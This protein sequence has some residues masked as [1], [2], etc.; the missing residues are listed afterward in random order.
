MNTR[1]LLRTNRAIDAAGLAACVVLT[2]VVYAVGIAPV[3]ARHD[4]YAADE[5]AYATEKSHAARLQE[6]LESLQARLATARREAAATTITLQPL[7]TTPRHVAK[8]SKLATGSGLQIDDIQTGAATPGEYAVAVPV[9]L[10]GTGTYTASTQFLKRLRRALPETA[11][12]SFALTGH[13]EDA[14]GA[15]TFRMDLT[16]H[17]TLRSAQA[18]PPGRRDEPGH[19][20]DAGPHS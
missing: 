11:V 4:A 8:I 16:W 20:P 2:L 5:A 19:E 14:S 13:T 6:T 17:A 15:A 18:P 1:D 9:H 7:A 10:A 3:L 12:Q